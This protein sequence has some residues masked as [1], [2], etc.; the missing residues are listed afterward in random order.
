MTLANVKKIVLSLSLLLSLLP[1]SSLAAGKKIAWI[2][3]SSFEA[4]CKTYHYDQ[5]LAELLPDSTV[6]CFAH[7]GDDAADFVKQYET[8]VSGKGYTDLV[9]YAGLNGLID[10]AAVNTGQKNLMKIF[11]AAETQNTRVIVVSAQPYKAQAEFLKKNHTWLTGKPGGIDL[12]INLYNTLDTNGDDIMDEKYGGDVLHT[13][14]TGYKLIFQAI[15]QEGFGSQ[16]GIVLNNSGASGITSEVPGAAEIVQKKLSNDEIA[17]LVSKPVPKIKIPG[18]NFSNLTVD[19]VETRPDGSVFISMPFIG[20]YLAASFKYIVI[21]AGIAATARL[22]FAGFLW[23]TPTGSKDEART[24]IVQSISGLMLAIGGYTI[25][26]T[27]NPKLVSFAE[28]SLPFVFGQEINYTTIDPAIFQSITGTAPPSQA[29]TIANAQKFGQDAGLPKC[30]MDTIMAMES[31]GKQNLIGHDENFRRNTKPVEARQTFL[32]SG[33]KYSGA[34]F[35]PPVSDS[36]QYDYKKYNSAKTINDDA[37]TFVNSPPDYGLDWRFTHGFGAGQ[38][39]FNGNS[40]CDGARGIKIKETCYNIPEL[41]DTTT[42]LKVTVLHVK[43]DYACAQAA[44]LTGDDLVKG[45]FAS[46]NAGCGGFKKKLAKSIDEVRNFSY[47]TKAF[48]LYEK[49]INK[50]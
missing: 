37:D 47:V 26:Y 25:L 34:T 14:S 50:I 11:T 45:T 24:M 36:S 2:G 16:Q 28:I 3:S 29:E 27:V 21:I 5:K 38:I 1:Y 13:N 40:T 19:D 32:I 48:P 39:T 35:T 7:S 44:G 12:F 49:C 18:L 30:F 31:G 20:E 17:T 33:K 43:D 6:N 8:N 15:T 9:I 10:N 23:A 46:Y 22:I 41:L 42:N 4:L